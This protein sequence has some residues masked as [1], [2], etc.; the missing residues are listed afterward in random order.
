MTEKCLYDGLL[1]S[2]APGEAG[3]VALFTIGAT[4][5]GAIRVQ[6]ALRALAERALGHGGREV[7]RAAQ[8][9]RNVAGLT[10]TVNHSCL[11]AAK[12]PDSGGDVVAGGDAV[13]GL[14][15]KSRSPA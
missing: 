8:G 10:A 5:L 13:V 7:E 6:L 11:D 2:H 15:R 1:S 14:S 3:L 12:E 9:R 4:T